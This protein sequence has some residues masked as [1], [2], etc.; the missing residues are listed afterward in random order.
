[1]DKPEKDWENIRRHAYRIARRRGVPYDLLEDAAQFACERLWIDGD[2]THADATVI[3]N[4]ITDWIRTEIGRSDRGQVKGG[5]LW[6]NEFSLD[7]V[8]PDGETWQDEETSTT[9]FYPVERIIPEIPRDVTRTA[10]TPEAVNK[11]NFIMACVAFGIKQRDIAK[12]LGVTEGAITR[13]LQSCQ[14]YVNK[15]DLLP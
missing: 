6:S 13:Q 9:D 4:K 7:Y 1:M 15:Q 3:W 8:G 14:K 11:K 2:W 12:C 5:V 10:L